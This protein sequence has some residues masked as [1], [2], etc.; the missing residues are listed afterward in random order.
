MASVLVLERSGSS[1][2][3]EDSRGPGGSRVEGAVEIDV[4]SRRD[5]AQKQEDDHYH[6][7]IVGTGS[8]SRVHVV[9]KFS[10][11]NRA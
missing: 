6:G 2:I 4:E 3:A 7:S 5:E 9:N 11:H 1:W 10:S 8:Y